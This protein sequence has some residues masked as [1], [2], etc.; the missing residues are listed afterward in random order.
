MSGEPQAKTYYVDANVLLR[1][2]AGDVPELAERARGLFRRAE[3]GQLGL[4]L[5]PLM[6]GEVAYILRAHYKWPLAQVEQALVLLFATET[7]SV[8]ER[9]VVERSL[10]LMSRANCDF[11]DAYFAV[12][13]KAVG[14]GIVSFDLKHAKRL[15]V[16]WLEP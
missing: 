8:P 11:E 9:G 3:A 2:L 16:E 5:H 6:I 7:F 14:G 1:F 10:G 12:Q 4:V 13:A 15:D